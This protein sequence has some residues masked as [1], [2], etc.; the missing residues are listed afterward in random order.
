MIGTRDSPSR[1][2][3]P[4]DR[5]SHPDAPLGRSLDQAMSDKPDDS[6]DGALACLG[7]TETAPSRWHRWMPPLRVP[8][9]G[10]AVFAVAAVTVLIGY[11]AFRPTLAPPPVAPTLP[12]FDSYPDE[13]I[14]LNQQMQR[15]M[16]QSE[17]TPAPT[18]MMK[19]RVLNRP[20]TPRKSISA[21]TSGD[22]S[23]D[24]AWVSRALLYTVME[25]EYTMGLTDKQR[26]NRTVTSWFQTVQNTMMA[27]LSGPEHS[28]SIDTLLDYHLAI[29]VTAGVDWEALT[30]N[31]KETAAF[32]RVTLLQSPAPLAGMVSVWRYTGSLRLDDDPSVSYDFHAIER[33]QGAQLLSTTITGAWHKEAIAL[34]LDLGLNDPQGIAS[35][36]HDL[37][38]I[39]GSARGASAEIDRGPYVV[40]RLTD[41]ELLRSF[42]A[43][44]EAARASTASQSAG[45]P[46][47]IRG[48]SDPII[49]F[50]DSITQYGSNL[51]GW[52]NLLSAA[53]LRV[54]DVINRGIQS[55]N[56]NVYTPASL[57]YMARAVIAPGRSPHAVT[58]F[59]GQ[60]DF[61]QGML[62][63]ALP[64]FEAQLRVMVFMVRTAWPTTRVIVMTP[65]M[66]ATGGTTAVTRMLK[67]RAASARAAASI[68]SVDVM[69]TWSTFLGPQWLTDT[70]KATNITVTA[71]MEQP[72][73]GDTLDEAIIT[74]RTPV[75]MEKMKA[76]TDD[77][78][79]LNGDGNAAL[80]ASVYPYVQ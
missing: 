75:W 22:A 18:P 34:Y 7:E 66:R 24:E 28:P 27:E 3:Y 17:E 15:F 74:E 38:N 64:L 42:R 65:H 13:M 56:T 40:A 41:M 14:P 6:P 20:R 19:R 62:G 50:G 37:D 68:P 55:S 11:L 70:T 33:Y 43:E 63:V 8:F 1:L 73:R 21:T 46:R 2:P 52:T 57:L 61:S 39:V 47:S 53:Q 9:I 79:H 77:G 45:P 26:A 16:R 59:W 51:A 60:N 76:L 67:Y 25:D 29:M 12:A 30:R 5:H 78:V 54:R 71:E 49:C 4:C 10:A 31:I 72:T 58:L 35:A 36:L 32:G 23:A 44:D 69:D 80:Y 48:W